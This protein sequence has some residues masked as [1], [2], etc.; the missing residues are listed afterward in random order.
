MRV[1]RIHITHPLNE[2]QPVALADKGIKHIKDVLRLTVG[3]R[4][5][6]FNGDGYDYQ[7]EIVELHKR[8]AVIQLGARKKIERESHL[9][10]HLLQPLCRSEK[11][12]WC[13]QKATELGVQT[14]T[15]YISSRVNLSLPSSKV[16][17]KLAHWQSV[18]YSACEQSGRAETPTIST[19]QDFAT[20]LSS[21]PDDAIKIIASPT[22]E[23]RPLANKTTPRCICAV[24]PEGGFTDEEIKL[25]EQVGFVSQRLGPRV[26]RLETAVIS[27]LTL[28]QAHCGD[29]N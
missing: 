20:V 22:A 18:I 12:D 13:L 9:H 28:Y 11:M 26:L 2:A 21:L 19:A 10:L 15:P 25:A 4:V 6:L 7:G 17:K 5:I 27:I 14:I 3:N 23:V 29:L 1:P 24:G 8:N 16:E